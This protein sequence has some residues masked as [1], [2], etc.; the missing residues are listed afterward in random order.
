MNTVLTIR[1]NF[2]PRKLSITQ[3]QFELTNKTE[4]LFGKKENR[5]KN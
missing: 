1:F 2:I 3:M 4:F 5:A